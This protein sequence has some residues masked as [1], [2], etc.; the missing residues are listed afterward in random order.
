MKTKLMTTILLT[1]LCLLAAPFALEQL[2]NLQ[3]VVGKWTRNTFMSSLVTVH[4]SERK[5]D[6]N[7]SAAHNHL[8]PQT[9]STSEEFRWSGRVAE[10]KTIEVKGINGG[11]R[12]E[13]AQGNEVEVI[14][15]KTGRRSDPKEVEI[16]VVEH[17]GGVT[18]CAVYPSPDSSRPND[19]VPGEGG[20]SNVQNN[21]VDVAFRVRVPR[22]V[23]FSG[24]TVNG[25]IDAATLGGD[26]DAKTVN[27][28]ININT[29]GVARAKT[30]N[31]SITASMGRAD[32]SAP[33]EFKTVNGA[34]NLELPPGTSAEV[35]AETF[36]GDI[37]T[38]FPITATGRVG[39]RHLN[40][41]IGAGGRELS[42]KTVNGSISLRGGSE[43]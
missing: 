34:I 26:V 36:N 35:K 2:D 10:G 20:N 1:A 40:G 29:A 38:T 22:G 19:C 12:A 30:V 33:L 23:R 4:A 37:N 7:F 5:A 21:D 28:S 27:G 15:T 8:V 31:G 11:V 24:R 43:R 9:A 39:R 42:I 18:I 32:W 14:A 25:G 16:R 3:H 17:G 6:E 13:P 41:T